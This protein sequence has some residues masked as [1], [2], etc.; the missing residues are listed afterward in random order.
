MILMDL[1]GLDPELGD[2]AVILLSAVGEPTGSLRSAVWMLWRDRLR[3]V[4]RMYLA[5]AASPLRA[6]MSNDVIIRQVLGRTE[7]RNQV[8]RYLL[9]L[10]GALEEEGTVSNL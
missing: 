5:G 7:E 6:K 1:H 2:L 3:Q 10:F 9:Y 8:H 4:I